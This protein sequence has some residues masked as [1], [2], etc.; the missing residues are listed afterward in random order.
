MFGHGKE[1][2]AAEMMAPQWLKIMIESRDIVNRTADPEVFFSRYALVIENAGKLARIS[3]YVKFKGMKPA[4][5]LRMAQ[6]QEEAATRDFILRYFQ[7]T[8]L[9]AEKVKT[10]R[11]K[12]SQFEKFQTALEPY[13]YQ[14]SAANVALVQQLHDEALAMIGG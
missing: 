8:L 12:C 10:V 6:E 4:E 3:K 5:V 11:G 9:N 7:K 14:M 1:K 2:A 13:Y